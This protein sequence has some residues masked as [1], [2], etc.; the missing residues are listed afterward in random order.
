VHNAAV[1]NGGVKTQ[2][3]KTTQAPKSPVVDSNSEPV[4]TAQESETKPERSSGADAEATGN[5]APAIEAPAVEADSVV[6]ARAVPEVQAAPADSATPNAETGDAAFGANV[7]SAPPA[8]D[9]APVAPA[10]E[11]PDTAPEQTAVAEADELERGVCPLQGFFCDAI[12]SLCWHSSASAHAMLHIKFFMAFDHANPDV[13]EN[14]DSQCFVMHS[15]RK[16]T[17]KC[18]VAEGAAF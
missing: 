3:A 8:E 2:E 9:A 12:C 17:G 5:V 10:P 11:V 15:I 4:E 13:G 16:R 1:A 14:G 18:C 7:V 6:E